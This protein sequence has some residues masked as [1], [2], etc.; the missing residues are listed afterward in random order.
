LFWLIPLR[1][2]GVSVCVRVCVCLFFCLLVLGV[3]MLLA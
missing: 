2:C 1:E 3:V